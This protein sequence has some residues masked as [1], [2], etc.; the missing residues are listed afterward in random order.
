M[1]IAADSGNTDG[2]TTVRPVA[3][4]RLNPAVALFFQSNGTRLRK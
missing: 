4:S 3:R 1:M 2:A